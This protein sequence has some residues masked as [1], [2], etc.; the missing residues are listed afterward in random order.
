MYYVYLIQCDAPR[1]RRY[2]GYTEDLR[3]R[4]LDHDSGRSVSTS[5]SKEWRLKT[6]VAFCTKD[7]ALVFE[8][9]LKSGSGHAFARKRLW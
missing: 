4:I 3:Q 2:V 7:H 8:R 1:R 5:G 6:C 9:Y